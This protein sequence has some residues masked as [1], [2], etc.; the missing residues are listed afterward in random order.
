MGKY[1]DLMMSGGDEEATPAPPPLNQPTGE[2][3]SGDSHPVV[4]A[5]KG[6]TG[7]L[8]PEDDPSKSAGIGTQAAASLPTD[9]M[10]RVKYFAAKR[11]G[12]DPKG[13]E[14]Y[15]ILGGRIF[16]VDDNGKAVYEEPGATINPRGL[17]KYGASMAGPAIPMVT[18]TAGGVGGAT[19]GP[20]A[21][22][23]GA[24]AGAG[25]GDII[26]QVLARHVT[27]E[28]KFDPVQT[29]KEALTAGV[30]QGAGHVAVKFANR[31]A[32][33]D[34]GALASPGAQ[35]R[36]NALQSA[37]KEY[38]VELTPAEITNLRSLR[39]QQ[40]VLQDMPRSADL[41]DDFYRRRAEEQIPQAMEKYLA[42]VSP[43]QSSEVGA[44]KL[45][46]GGEKAVASRKMA[47]AEFSGHHY[48]DAME[49][50]T[51][52]DIEPVIQNV[53]ARA[54]NAKGE[55]KSVLDKAKA[56][57]Y[58]T[59]EVGPNGPAQVPDTTVGGLHEAKL[60]ID[61]LIEGRG[62]NAISGVA[63]RELVG[64]QKDLVK[65]LQKASPDYE[66]GMA[67][68]KEGS[69]AISDLTEGL[70]GSATAGKEARAP[71]VMFQGGPGAIND[72]RTAFERSGAMDEWNAGLRS[73]LSEAFSKASKEFKSGNLAAGANFRSA[74]Y[75]TPRQKAE[76]R[77]AM[78]P[79]QWQSFEKM[80]DVFEA[81]GRVP[82][83]GSMTEFNRLAVEEMKG[84]GRGLPGMALKIGTTAAR[85]HQWG[86]MLNGFYERLKMGSHSEELAKIITS[87]DAMNKLR[88]L[89][90]LPPRSERARLIVGQVLSQ[91]GAGGVGAVANPAP[92]GRVV[93]EPNSASPE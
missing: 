72:A 26:R 51:P 39:G 55:I 65:A 71:M 12:D 74:V 53:E 9:L 92:E 23:G 52:V 90:T 35:N 6:S 66:T 21:G 44:Q 47:R 62:E 50:D 1:E 79:K 87:P 33:R 16:Y 68:F 13:M 5:M 4:K 34:L 37:A 84:E 86:E 32:A 81:T 70:V 78:S 93:L 76:L 45:V 54:K 28:E 15:G 42:Q 56:Y 27:G 67:V 59:E 61:A 85:P 8:E 38:G 63:K 69:P 30:G 58:R 49:K 11:F 88:A 43:V 60:A 25:A 77:A 18:G 64:L 24:S 19:L 91:A 82:G 31:M 40:R 14:R 3:R 80:M 83:G 57:L 10:T 46:E 7:T 75:G 2:L 22:V 73:Y 36:L 41:M 29:A 48:R 17:V 89:K 20:V